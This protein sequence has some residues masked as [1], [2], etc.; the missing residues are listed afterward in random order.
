MSEGK[1]S[2]L[3][4]EHYLSSEFC[5]RAFAFRRLFIF[6]SSLVFFFF[7]RS[8]QP[9]ST[10]S[11]SKVNFTAPASN[12]TSGCVQKFFK[13][14][15]RTTPNFYQKNLSILQLFNFYLFYIDHVFLFILSGMRI[16]FTS[17]LAAC[18][19]S[20][21]QIQQPLESAANFRL[22]VFFLPTEL[23]MSCFYPLD[24]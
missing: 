23:K 20:S 8:Q 13:V 17:V 7:Y 10:Q 6:H 18:L 14:F 3:L 15:S 5:L 11:F 21:Q 16:F 22:G 9:S 2:S 1:V 24:C 12:C 4:C 19:F